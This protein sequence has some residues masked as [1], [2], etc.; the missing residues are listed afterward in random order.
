[1]SAESEVVDPMTVTAPAMPF[2]GRGGRQLVEAYV[3]FHASQLGNEILKTF[4]RD[5]VA[6]VCTLLRSTANELWDF[7]AA[8]DQISD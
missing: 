2:A 4:E 8:V 5:G 6:G 7:T 3:R 1:M